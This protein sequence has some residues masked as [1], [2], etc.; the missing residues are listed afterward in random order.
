[1]TV[2]DL[3]QKFPHELLGPAEV[4][5]PL[6]EGHDAFRGVY[7]RGAHIRVCLSAVWS[8]VES[9]GERANHVLLYGLP[10]CAKTQILLGLER[11][12][13][14]GSVLRL[15]STSTT[16]AG[17]ERLIFEK[18]RQVPPLIFME[19]IE[20]AQEGAAGVAGGDGRPPWF[21]KVTHNL[22]R[23]RSVHF[24]GM[25]T[26]N[27]KARFDLMMGG[28]AGRSRGAVV[29]V[30][31]PAGVPPPTRR[32]CDASC[33]T[34]CRRSRARR[35]GS[36][37]AWSWPEPWVPMIRARC[38]L[39]STAATGCSTAATSD[40]LAVCAKQAGHRGPS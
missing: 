35:S 4:C 10:A 30:P 6:I 18:L 8:F 5:D 12:F 16:R 20:K 14:P 3:R 23:L 29:P 2:E 22:V 40:I 36:S 37:R 39:S 15:D 25:A 7:G 26:A 19:E 13:G 38:S 9:G 1:M 28:G 21:R 31:A 17:L 34:T 24:L 11:I 33:C 32:R 27:D